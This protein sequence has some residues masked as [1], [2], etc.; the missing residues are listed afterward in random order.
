[1]VA[2]SVD[3]ASVNKGSHKGLK[4][5]IQNNPS[6]PGSDPNLEYWGWWWVLF[7]H[8][9]NHL[10]ESFGVGDLKHADAFVQQFNDDL[11]KVF[12]MYH[13]STVLE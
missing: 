6:A 2:T 13:C 5:P 1:M 10:L 9:V 7:I 3:G 4:A 11:K 8:C 12:S